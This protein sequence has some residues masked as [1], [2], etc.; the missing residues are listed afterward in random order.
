MNETPA[1]TVDLRHLADALTGAYPSLDAADK[2]IAMATYGLLA[3]GRPASAQEIAAR[4]SVKPADVAVRMGAWPGVFCDEQG[5]VVGF[6]GLTITEMPPH[7]LLIGEVRLWAW[8][9]WDTLF[10]PARL[11]TVLQVRS[12]CPVTRETVELRVAPDRVQTVVPDGVVVSFLSP[13]RRFEGNVIT[14]FC[15]FVHFFASQ[16]AGEQWIEQHPATFLLSLPDAVEL[17]RLSNPWLGLGT[18]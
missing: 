3:R 2:R 10:L 9:A 13:E 1:A 12:V 11:G 6:W 4:A 5:R 16:R 17:A 7:E 14:S 8:C 18:A 15:H